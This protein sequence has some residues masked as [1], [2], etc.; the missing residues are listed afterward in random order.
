MKNRSCRPLDPKFWPKIQM[1][2]YEHA[3]DVGVEHKV[4][5]RVIMFDEVTNLTCH[6]ELEWGARAPRHRDSK[7][8][9]VIGGIDPDPVNNERITKW[10]KDYWSALH[11][12]S[13][14]GAYVNFMM[15]EGQDRIKATYGDNYERLV[16]VKRKWDPANI[17][18]VNQNIN[19]TPS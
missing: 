6:E 5:R 7:W 8:S 14:G 3:V 1:A 16:A 17:F 10:A 11:P 12:Y 13:A 15:E 4:A 19:P 2:P 9:M 18:R